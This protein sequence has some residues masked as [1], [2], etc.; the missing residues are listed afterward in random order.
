MLVEM[1]PIAWDREG[2]G[3]REEC[4]RKDRPVRRLLG[5]FSPREEHVGQN[6]E[7]VQISVGRARG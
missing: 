3:L 2:E 4:R 7:I 5:Q 1:G 6:G